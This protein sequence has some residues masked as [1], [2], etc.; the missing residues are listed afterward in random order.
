[1]GNAD[2]Q[3]TMMVVSGVNDRGCRWSEKVLPMGFNAV[4]ALDVEGK[5][6][7]TNITRDL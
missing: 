5:S 7:R 3:R 1:V 6:I 4:N 2:A